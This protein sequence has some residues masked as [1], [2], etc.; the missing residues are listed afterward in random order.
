MYMIFVLCTMQHVFEHMS[1]NKDLKL[2]SRTISGWNWTHLLFAY[3]TKV[4]QMNIFF[5]KEDNKVGL[6]GSLQRKM[7]L[8]TR[9]KLI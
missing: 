4:S 5:K 3:Q 7:F 1:S 8:K 6:L 9:R 2:E